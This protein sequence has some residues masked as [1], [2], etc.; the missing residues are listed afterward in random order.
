MTTHLNNEEQECK[1][2]HVKGRVLVT[3]VRGI[4]EETKGR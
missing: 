1:M 2:S 4:N 3:S